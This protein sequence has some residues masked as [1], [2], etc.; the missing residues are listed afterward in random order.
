[1]TAIP[2]DLVE[3][4][5]CYSLFLRE[6]TEPQESSLRIVLEEASCWL[7]RLRLRLAEV[8]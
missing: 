8:R 3:I 7:R 5:S 4:D 1:M 6:I 2:N